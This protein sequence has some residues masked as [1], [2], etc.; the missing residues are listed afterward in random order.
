MATF[1]VRYI[2]DFETRQRVNKLVRNGKCLVDDFE[3]EIRKDKNLE[4]ELDEIVATIEDV[5]NGKIV[6]R[7]QYRKLNLS[8]KLPY[9]A[10]E[11][12]SKH[13][14]PLPDS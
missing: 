8:G 13:L 5:A 7:N 4:P 10:F 6:P 3:S 1:D 12:K 9:A 2:P 14:R 11:A